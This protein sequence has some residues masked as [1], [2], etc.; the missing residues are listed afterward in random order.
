MG[1]WTLR[2]GWL[3]KSSY[4]VQNE[5][6]ACQ[7]TDTKVPP[8]PPQKKKKKEI[9]GHLVLHLVFQVKSN[10]EFS[11]NLELFPSPQPRAPPGFLLVTQKFFPF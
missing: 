7:L 2:N 1:G 10:P 6:L 9:I 5:L 8:A 11:F 3:I 4:T